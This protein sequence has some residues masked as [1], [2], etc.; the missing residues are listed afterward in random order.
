MTGGQ[1]HLDD[2]NL[3]CKRFYDEHAP[4][5]KLT[6]KEVELMDKPWLTKEI[7]DKCQS[8][9]SI[10]KEIS[11][12]PDPKRIEEL[13]SKLKKIRNEITSEKRKSKKEHLQNFFETN[14]NFNLPIVFI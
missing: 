2:P 6:K 10:L 1:I 7:L 14:K 4:Y 5:R 13:K 3:S 12:E 9:D 11:N 8:R